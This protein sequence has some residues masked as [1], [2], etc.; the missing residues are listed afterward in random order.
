M[1]DKEAPI[2]DYAVRFDLALLPGIIRS[3]NLMSC[4]GLAEQS[5]DAYRDAFRNLA[6]Q[7]R[8]Q[9]PL[10]H[11][12][13]VHEAAWFDMAT[14]LRTATQFSAKTIG[15][16]WSDRYKTYV[17]VGNTTYVVA[18]GKKDDPVHAEVIAV[19]RAAAPS[20]ANWLPGWS[21]STN[22]R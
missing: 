22:Q 18:S 21:P 14:S 6:L 19:V 17:L 16:R 13:K 4:V 20:A 7:L 3:L 1:T 9:S 2:G 15:E 12:D 10:A 11:L 8:L 5:S